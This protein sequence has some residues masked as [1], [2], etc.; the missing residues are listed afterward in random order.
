MYEK[1]EVSGSGGTTSSQ[2]CQC[3]CRNLLSKKKTKKKT[4]QFCAYRVQPVDHSSRWSSKEGIYEVQ[5]R[6]RRRTTTRR[7]ECRARLSLRYSV[8]DLAIN[9]AIGHKQRRRTCRRR[10][11][12]SR[13]GRSDGK[14]QEASVSTAERLNQSG[15]LV[16]ERGPS[17]KRRKQRLVSHF[18]AL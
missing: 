2:I 5:S 12:G 8:C 3:Q 7:V 18:F 1:V 13:A 6:W 15:R 9:I 14:S 16:V 4:L 11:A 10:L 17:C